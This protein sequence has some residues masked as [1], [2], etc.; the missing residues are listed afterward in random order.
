MD[1]LL[2]Q[3]PSDPG[4]YALILQILE[5]AAIR[6]GSLGIFQLVP[7][8]YIY[9]G[10]AFGPGG[11]RAR[12]KHHLSPVRSPH[13]HID[14]L[15]QSAQVIDIIY[16][17]CPDRLEHLWAAELISDPKFSIPIPRFGASDCRCPTHLFF[18]MDYPTTFRDSPL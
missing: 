10:S 8:F 4:T 16:R 15:R 6:A 9:L 7:G 11:I 12:L 18:S 1:F 13:W 3:L 14:Y 5:P 17:C 2:N